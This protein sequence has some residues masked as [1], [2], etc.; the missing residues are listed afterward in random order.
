MPS[1]KSTKKKPDP[2]GLGDKIEQFT[3]ATGIK[4]AVKAVFGEDCGCDERRKT[5]NRLFPALT[6]FDDNQKARYEEYV[7]PYRDQ[8]F[9]EVPS[10]NAK[11][12]G[13]LYFEMTGKNENVTGCGSCLKTVKKALDKIYLFCDEE[14]STK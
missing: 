5:L 9:G 3:E 1:K 7:L 10:R 11:A 2:K 12:M 13:N 4:A 14:D 6:K 8:E